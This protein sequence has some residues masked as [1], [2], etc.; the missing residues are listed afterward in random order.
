VRQRRAGLAGWRCACAKVGG[1]WGSG[2]RGY[3]AADVDDADVHA[4]TAVPAPA[5]LARPTRAPDRSALPIAGDDAAAKSQ[6][7][8]LLDALG[9]DAVDLGPLTDSWRAQPGGPVYV[10]PYFPAPAAGSDVDP[11]AWF[12]D[13]PGTPVPAWRVKEL[14]AAVVRA[15]APDARPPPGGPGRRPVPCDSATKGLK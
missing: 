4:T 14:A 13:S 3:V 11:R 1:I 7:A 10:Q 8:A 2:G 6:A 9:Y 12:T 5:R 15:T